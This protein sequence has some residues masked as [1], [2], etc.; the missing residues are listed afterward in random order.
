LG[1]V[2]E[3]MVGEW[4]VR[5]SAVGSCARE[6][7]RERARA[8]ARERRGEGVKGVVEESTAHQLSLGEF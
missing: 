1:K 3:C 8:R 4:M 6:R 2:T 5:V 7:E